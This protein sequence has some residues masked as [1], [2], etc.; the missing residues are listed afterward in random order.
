MSTRLSARKPEWLERKE[1][2]QTV[3]Y[4]SRRAALNPGLVLGLV[5]TSSN[6]HKF[7]LSATGERG[8]MAVAPSWSKTTGDGDPG[9]LF[10]M[11]TN[12]RF[13][14]VLLR[15]FLDQ[16]GGDVELAVKDYY[17]SNIGATPDTAAARDFVRR[18]SLNAQHW[19]YQDVSPAAQPLEVAPTI[20]AVPAKGPFHT[21]AIADSNDSPCR[22][23]SGPGGACYSGPGGGLYSGPGGGRYSGPSGG[24]YSGPG[25]GLYVGP[26]GGMYSG[27]DGGLYTGPGGGLYSGPG[28]GIYAG[29]PSD[30]G[31]KGP[32]GPCIT[33]VLGTAWKR[34]NCPN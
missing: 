7:F 4:E 28:G 6:F 5:E 23:Y 9:K 8:Y 19:S 30:D 33:G 1:F 13:G 20:T 15:H 29:P 12:L 3:W 21:A 31:Y 10:H 17:A 14:C 16:R 34:Q 24:L 27:P 18:V 32:W 25:G 26:G 22:G 2:L 11:Q